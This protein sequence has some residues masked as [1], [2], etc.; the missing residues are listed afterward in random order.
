[1]APVYQEVTILFSLA[2]SKD[3]LFANVLSDISVL[4]KKSVTT[5]DENIATF[6]YV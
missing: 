5:S 3:A 6:M 1:M 2:H 4:R